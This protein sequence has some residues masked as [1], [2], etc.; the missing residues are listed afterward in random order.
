MA[1]TAQEQALLSALR[2]KRARMRDEILAEHTIL[3]HES[4]LGPHAQP[5]RQPPS[6]P[7]TAGT[8]APRSSNAHG[9]RASYGS[10]TTTKG[11]QRVLLYLDRPVP[12]PHGFDT[13]EPSPDLSDFL[14][15]GSD[16]DEESTPRSSWL[17]PAVVEEEEGLNVGRPDSVM[18]GLG[19]GMGVGTAGRTSRSQARLSAVG[20]SFGVQTSRHMHEVK[21]LGTERD[22]EEEGVVWGM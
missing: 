19:V 16:E 8:Q 17:P 22:E 5:Q 20:K 15:F 12:A 10:A 9:G 14:S 21:V 1:V 4:A 7:S 13:A 2:N 18:E 6:P 11:K 3:G